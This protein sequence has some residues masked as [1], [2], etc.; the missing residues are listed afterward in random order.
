MTM[1]R[2]DSYV[3][4]GVTYLTY[5]DNPM[6]FSKAW[7]CR[8]TRRH[9]FVNRRVTHKRHTSPE[10]MSLVL[11]HWIWFLNKLVKKPD[12]ELSGLVNV[13]QAMSLSMSGIKKV[14]RG[15]PLSGQLS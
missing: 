12:L 9:G 11:K 8:W 3:H 7:A 10:V 15:E 14:G 1:E 13:D 2:L 5:R 6:K 4:K